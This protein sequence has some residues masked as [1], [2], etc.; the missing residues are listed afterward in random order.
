[1]LS[2]YAYLPQA[3]TPSLESALSGHTV[4]RIADVAEM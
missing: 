1:M 2:S 4:N 3:A